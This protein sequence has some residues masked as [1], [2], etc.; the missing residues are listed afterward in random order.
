MA[1]KG[2][3]AAGELLPRTGRTTEP[4]PDERCSAEASV[5]TA[6]DALT[7][8]AK[9]VITLDKAGGTA[10]THVPPGEASHMIT[11][12]GIV[13]TGCAGIGGAVL[14]VWFSPGLAGLALADLMLTFAIVVVTAAVGLIRADKR[15]HGTSEADSDRRTPRR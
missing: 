14:M 11:T 8:S 2:S 5:P 13:V 15:G 12:F 10:E 4:G 6:A 7:P 9:L 3:R 1:R